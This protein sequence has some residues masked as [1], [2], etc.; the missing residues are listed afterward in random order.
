MML[1]E[2]VKRTGFDLSGWR[3]S[4][5]RRRVRKRTSPKC[6]RKCQNESEKVQAHNGIDLSGR[7]G[8][9]SNE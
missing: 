8:T 7:Q 2:F 1:S 6:K 3:L 4:R 5:L 9:D